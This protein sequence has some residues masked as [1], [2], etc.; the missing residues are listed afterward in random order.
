MEWALLAV[1]AISNE[2]PQPQTR[3]RNLVP[4]RPRRALQLRLN[5][6]HIIREHAQLRGQLACG[7]SGSGNQ[8][9]RQPTVRETAGGE[10][11]QLT[12]SR[13]SSGKVGSLS[14]VNW[15]PHD[16]MRT[17]VHGLLGTELRCHQGTRACNWS[18][19][20]ALRSRCG[21][22]ATMAVPSCLGG[23]TAK[24]QVTH[25]RAATGAMVQTVLLRAGSSRHEAPLSAVDTEVAPCLP[26]IIVAVTCKSCG[27][28]CHMVCVCVF[29]VWRS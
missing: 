19:V 28:Q 3:P 2:A 24:L 8:R 26:F 6:R 15:L 4:T 20:H 5:A 29:H 12:S 13:R 22:Q 18:P 1:P 16:L 11:H 7:A 17:G 27:W 10:P 14:R 23:C 21:E 9:F 25:H